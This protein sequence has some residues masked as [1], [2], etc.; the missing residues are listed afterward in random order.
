MRRPIPAGPVEDRSEAAVMELNTITDPIMSSV[1]PSHLEISF[2]T[3]NVGEFKD[4]NRSYNPH[5]LLDKLNMM[6][7]T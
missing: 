4:F 2:T 7:M 5:P 1:R 6:T 3:Q